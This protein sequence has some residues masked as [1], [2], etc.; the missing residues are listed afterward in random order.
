MFDKVLDT[1]VVFMLTVANSQAIARTPARFFF[2]S[3]TYKQHRSEIGQ[4]TKS[5][6]Y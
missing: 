6:K 5:G 2:I 3:N 1:P 4:K